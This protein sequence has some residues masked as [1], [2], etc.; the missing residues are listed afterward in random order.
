MN[1]K[2]AMIIIFGILALSIPL[3]SKIALTQQSS[4]YYDNLL[5]RRA[6]TI[7][8]SQNPNN[9]NDYQVLITMDT[10]SLISEGKMSSDCSD[11]RFTGYNGEGAQIEIPYWIESGC[12][13]PDTKIWVKVPSIPANGY[14]TVYAYYGNT[15]PVTSASNGTATFVYFNDF[16][17]TTECNDISGSLTKTCSNGIM[18]LTGDGVDNSLTTFTSYTT[19]AGIEARFKAKDYLTGGYGFGV[20]FGDSSTY[21]YSVQYDRGA[22]AYT[23]V[24]PFASQASDGSLTSDSNW[25]IYIL[26]YDQNKNGFI[27]VIEPDGSITTV[28][29][30]TNSNFG[31]ENRIAFREW[32][33]SQTAGF[34][35]VYIRKYSSPDPT[36]SIGAE[37]ETKPTSLAPTYITDCTN[38]TQPGEY[39]LANDIIDSNASTCISIQADNVTFDCQGHTI[40]GIGASD[41]Y[42][43]YVGGHNYV[44]IENCVLSD[45]FYG[46]YLSSSSKNNIISNNT[47]NSN[48][49]GIYLYLSSNNIIS[50]NTVNS[51]SYNGIFLYSSPNNN[52]ISNN[53]V[54]NNN[55]YGIVLYSSSNNTIYNNLFNNTNN[56]YFYGDIYANYWNTTLQSGTNIVGGPYIGGNYWGKPDGTGYSDTC[57]DANND[58]ICD[59]P[60]TLNNNNIDY[61]P[62]AKAPAGAPYLQVTPNY[63]TVNFGMLNVSSIDNPAPNQ[64]LGVYNFTINT[65]ANYKVSIYGN[66]FSSQF[67]INNL[68]FQATDSTSNINVANAITL[69]T[70]P[71]SAG[72]FSPSVTTL[73]HAYWLTIPSNTLAGIYHT[74]V[75]ID[76]SLA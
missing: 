66:D 19:S 18:D 8:N 33:I 61:L 2:I 59:S 73:Y 6:I 45:W 51:N 42:G 60:Y 9:L 57:T 31:S 13:T 56:Y 26:A 49:E 22:G 54:N 65:N 67:T 40:D 10:Q 58:G 1:K 62:L 32:D 29:S 11:L 16:L 48:R 69:S 47:V 41:S 36:Y 44:T 30:G 52:I 4:W 14:A 50:N 38:I 37:E 46:I 71:Q 55:N 17:T 75:Y 24:I 25:R 70:S 27:K 39:V 20:G 76:I 35:W 63:D 72:T 12:N 68:K 21:I 43:I 74:T 28:W 64:E 23:Y 34:D 53:I 3:F 7:D 15:T 5:Y